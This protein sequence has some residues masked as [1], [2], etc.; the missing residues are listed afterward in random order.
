MS[1]LYKWFTKLYIWATEQLYHRFAW[2]YDF[3]AWLVSFGN[4]SS[5]R[6]SVM[7]YLQPGRVLEIGFGTGELLVT[8]KRLGFDVYGLEPSPQMQRIT[9]RRGK[10]EGISLAVVQASAQAIP[11]PDHSFEN[12]VSTFP[13]GYIVD[14]DSLKEIK[15]VLASGGRVLIT[16]FGVRFNSG[17]QNWL[18]HW[19]LNKG[20]ELFIQS[21]CQRVQSLG[22]KPQLIH[23]K[24]GSFTLPIIILENKDDT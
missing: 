10:R 1:F 8:S 2:A 7:N 11:F 14:P 21:F 17:L 6:K 16:G 4:W 15:R 3:V 9:R 19:F 22:F 5:W 18:T 12:I 23:Y 20:N 24:G 13:S